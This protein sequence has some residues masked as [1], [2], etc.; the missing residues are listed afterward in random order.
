[1]VLAIHGKACPLSRCLTLNLLNMCSPLRVRGRAGDAPRVCVIFVRDSINR[2]HVKQKLCVRW[3][4]LV[5]LCCITVFLLAVVLVEEGKSVI[6]SQSFLSIKQRSTLSTHTF[7]S[8]EHREVPDL[9]TDSPFIERNKTGP[10]WKLV[11]LQCRYSAAV[12]TL[13]WRQKEPH[14]SCTLLSLPVFLEWHNGC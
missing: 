4:L 12:P 11:L 5:V 9:S 14:F 13:R 10:V 1:M 6:I 2:G 8:L 3:E 7:T